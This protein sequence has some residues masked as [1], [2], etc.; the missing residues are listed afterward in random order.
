M[1]NRYN[2]LK[3]PLLLADY[4]VDKKDDTNMKISEALANKSFMSEIQIEEQEQQIDEPEQPFTDIGIDNRKELL[5]LELANKQAE[6]ELLK[7][8]QNEQ[9]PE[10]NVS[11]FG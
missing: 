3:F 9:K 6:I 10:N 5:Q 1:K 2:H 8:K 4:D 7:L 11:M